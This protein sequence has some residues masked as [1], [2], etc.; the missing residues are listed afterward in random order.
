MRAVL[1][2]A[3]DSPTLSSQGAAVII[4]STLLMARLRPVRR[5]GGEGGTF[6]GTKPKEANRFMKRSP[7]RCL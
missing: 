4:A 6:V 2:D 5:R 7:P 3:G 1:Q